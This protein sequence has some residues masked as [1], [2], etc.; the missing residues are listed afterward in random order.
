M[1]LLRNEFT[2]IARNDILQVQ[3]S[4]VKAAT[5]SHANWLAGGNLRAPVNTR[6]CRPRFSDFWTILYIFCIYPL[7]K[8]MSAVLLEKCNSYP[9]TQQFSGM[10]FKLKFQCMFRKACLSLLTFLR[11]ASLAINGPSYF[12][13]IRVGTAHTHATHTCVYIYIYIYV[14]NIFK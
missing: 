2:K 6:E 5:Y 4:S 8:S 11:Q 9:F 1:S 12:I 3:R 7:T 10:I 14:N 13:E